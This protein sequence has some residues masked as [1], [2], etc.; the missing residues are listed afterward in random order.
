V[1]IPFCLIQP[2]FY[3]QIHWRYWFSLKTAIFRDNVHSVSHTWH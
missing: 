1:E 2:I 3:I